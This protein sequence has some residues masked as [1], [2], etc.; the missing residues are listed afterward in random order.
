MQLLLQ[1]A[2]QSISKRKAS[3]ASSPALDAAAATTAA[4][5]AEETS[6]S[7]RI[8][9]GSDSADPPQVHLTL[10]PP[11]PPVVVAHASGQYNV[12]CIESKDLNVGATV[13]G[14]QE[15]WGPGPEEGKGW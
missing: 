7:K 12:I 1:E 4:A 11:P 10:L 5:A 3:D 15:E 6:P 8:K 2:K 14:L 9:A 13:Q